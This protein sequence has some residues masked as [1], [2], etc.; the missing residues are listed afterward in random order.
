MGNVAYNPLVAPPPF[1]GAAVNPHGAADIYFPNATCCRAMRLLLRRA[2]LALD[3]PSISVSFRE[4]VEAPRL[5]V[6]NRKLLLLHYNALKYMRVS[7]N[8]KLST[9]R[10]EFPARILRK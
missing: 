6:P 1:S 7:R 5:F 8:C 10:R 9:M 4:F 2:R 3:A